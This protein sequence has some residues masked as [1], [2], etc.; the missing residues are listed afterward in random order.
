MHYQ[1]NIIVNIT[2]ITSVAV[3]SDEIVY[4]KIFYTVGE[5][6]GIIVGIGLI[7]TGLSVILAIIFTLKLKNVKLRHVTRSLKSKLR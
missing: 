2:T 4:I 3:N 1:V 6:T 7:I 5:L